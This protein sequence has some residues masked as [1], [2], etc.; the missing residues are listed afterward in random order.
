MNNNNC[1]LPY[2]FG[3]YFSEIDLSRLF[4]YSDPTD[5]T[6]KDTLRDTSDTDSRR[7]MLEKLEEDLGGIDSFMEQCCGMTID[8]TDYG[9]LYKK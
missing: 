8:F 4:E 3:R 5:L 1:L 7:W 9:Q 6:S 2:L